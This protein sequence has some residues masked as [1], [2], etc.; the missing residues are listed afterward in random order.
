M[1]TAILGRLVN[2]A[3]EPVAGCTVFAT[4]SLDSAWSPR[5]RQE[6]R[7]SGEDG[8]FEIPGFPWQHASS[9]LVIA[10]EDHGQALSVLAE[11]TIRQ[12][13][14]LTAEMNAPS[15]S[16]L[17]SVGDD[18]WDMG[19][20]VVP[21]HWSREE[22]TKASSPP[23]WIFTISVPA[24]DGLPRAPAAWLA[25]LGSD[26]SEPLDEEEKRRF[27]PNYEYRTD[28][29]PLSEW[30][31][32]QLRATL[33]FADGRSL[34]L[35]SEFEM[36]E[37]VLTFPFHG[38][39]PLADVRQLVLEGFDLETEILE[40][41]EGVRSGQVF[42]QRFRHVPVHAV[43]ADLRPA[44]VGPG[45]VH[46]D[47]ELQLFVRGTPAEQRPPYETAYPGMSEVYLS[48]VSPYPESTTTTGG[49]ICIRVPDEGPWWIQVTRF[50]GISRVFPTLQMLGPVRPSTEVQVLQLD[51][52]V[53]LVPDEQHVPWEHA[54][55]D[56][57]HD[58]ESDA[59]LRFRLPSPWQEPF[60]GLGGEDG[61]LDVIELTLVPLGD[62]GDLD[63]PQLR[64][65]DGLLRANVVPGHYSME[66][67]VFDRWASI[68]IEARRGEVVDLGELSLEPMV[69]LV[70]QLPEF[71]S[72]GTRFEESLD[73]FVEIPGARESIRRLGATPTI[74][75]NSRLETLAFLVP[76]HGDLVVGRGWYDDW[77]PFYWQERIGP[78][79]AGSKHSLRAPTICELEIHVHGIPS[80]LSW[81]W[82]WV[83][84]GDSDL[85]FSNFGGS[86]PRPR[87]PDGTQIH[88]L[89]GLEGPMTL[90][91]VSAYHRIE[92][93]LVDLEP[94]RTIVHVNA[95]KD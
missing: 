26:S 50:G 71:S 34:R 38:T 47:N 83:L 67:R 22:E 78:R 63:S 15:S 1:P 57:M 92:P 37:G 33:R 31:A 25:L 66:L 42:H 64:I 10:R 82:W 28:W 5:R 17:A 85:G 12:R 8:S 65:R 18:V 89:V 94:P 90:E 79:T 76:T 51:K 75:H 21:Q 46:R 81:D 16:R 29:P 2:E 41:P 77:N 74:L 91:G 68:E 44:P 73:V 27:T 84:S 49:P 45:P 13:S 60:L 7:T 54:A 43:F 93:M 24:I 14:A 39:E 20:L 6:S 48:I 30:T 95:T 52:A 70:V 32:D 58:T 62:D 9:L 19:M 55:F 88:R 23:G 53:R 61:L 72:G 40:C 80:G 3:G 59:I 35:E 4:E 86:F 11:A 56:S 36:V 87:L 69:P